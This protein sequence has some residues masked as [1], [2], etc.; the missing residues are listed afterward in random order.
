MENEENIKYDIISNWV[1]PT[2]FIRKYINV[3]EFP[4][5]FKDLRISL[6]NFSGNIPLR[7]RI[8][9]TWYL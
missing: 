5:K 9:Y 4:S 8:F 3:C 1:L 7:V 2:N 6:Y